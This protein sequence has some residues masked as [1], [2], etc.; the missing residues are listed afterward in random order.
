MIGQLVSLFAKGKNTPNRLGWS[1]CIRRSWS[2]RSA[3]PRFTIEKLASFP[4]LLPFS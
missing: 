4:Q 3:G 1:N 2:D